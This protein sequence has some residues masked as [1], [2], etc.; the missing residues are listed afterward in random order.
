MSMSI[1]EEN[2]EQFLRLLEIELGV[3]GLEKVV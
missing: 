1:R 3:F 2:R